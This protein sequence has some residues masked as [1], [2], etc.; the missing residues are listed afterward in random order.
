MPRLFKFTKFKLIAG[1]LLLLLLAAVAIVFVYQKIDQR[2][3]EEINDTDARQKLLLISNTLARLNEAESMGVAF[4]QR[5]SD[6]LLNDYIQNMNL[7]RRHLD[8]LQV[9]LSSPAQQSQIGTVNRL[10]NDKIKNVRELVAVKRLYPDSDFYDRAVET[11]ESLKDTVELI[12]VQERT[13]HRLDTT[14]VDRSNRIFGIRF[15]KKRIEPEISVVERQVFD[16]I[17]RHDPHQT[18]TILNT[19]RSVLDDYQDVRLEKAR[20]LHETEMAVI[21]SG[22]KITEQIQQVLND[23]EKEEVSYTLNRLKERQEA[24]RQL[25]RTIGAIAIMALLLSVLFVSLIF[26][27]ISRSQRY[28]RELEE[29]N[30][31]AER[32]LQGRERLML[33][34]SHD[35]K[36]PLNSISGHIELLEHTTLTDRQ[37]HYLQSMNSS[38]GHILRLVNNLLD[39]ARLESGKMPVETVPY[40]PALLLG[41][42]VE[43]F[44]PQALQKSLSLESHISRNLDREFTGDPLKI[45]QI[46][47]NLLSNALKYT[48]EGTIE[49]SAFTSGSDPLSLVIIV[50]DT[51][52]GMTPQEQE[53]IFEEFNRLD[54][55][56]NRG[57]EG[58]GLGLTITRQLVVLLGG[59]LEVESQKGVGSRFTLRFPLNKELP[60]DTEEETA[61]PSPVGQLVVLL[62]DDDPS[63]LS[64]TAEFL[65]HRGVRCITS[66]EA[67]KVLILLKEHSPDIVL[68]D[69]HMPLMSGFELVGQ[70]RKSENSETGKLP[71]VALSA[72]DNKTEADYQAAGFSAYL[73]KPYTPA[74]LQCCI[75]RLTGFR[76]EET[77]LP[78]ETHNFPGSTGD[79]ALYD[80]QGI[81]LFA[82]DDPR[83]VREII[84]SFATDCRDHFLRLQL[85]AEAGDP[86]AISQLAHKML[87]MFRQLRILTLVPTLEEWERTDLSTIPPGDLQEKI[88]QLCLS[89]EDILTR[90]INETAEL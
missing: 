13:V 76:F 89:G 32:L 60:A 26:S 74:Q 43:S 21:R 23:V 52:S 64:M 58:T 41:E 57:E 68:T 16:T 5:V 37:H 50:R 79:N 62:I 80:L 63:Q 84:S 49:F 65:R 72:G 38:A 30:R 51:G 40:N 33:T 35:I 44:L 66:T 9:L 61:L 78:A 31:L 45:R 42:T 39:Y 69:I 22:Q 14:L 46:V 77:P 4:S 85:L 56:H 1:Y 19:I 11:L 8:T 3:E 71:V 90:L 6:K 55:Q 7:V 86:A 25:T 75:T 54:S 88:R 20:R 12:D 17:A 87:P 73:N 10:L 28:R 24:S 83:G 29:A 36:S 48:H 67:D 27:D 81:R 59:T 34:V 70:I 15:G 53:V 2:Q 18:D 47:V 82:D